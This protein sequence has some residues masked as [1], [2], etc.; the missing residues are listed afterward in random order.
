MSYKLGHKLFFLCFTFYLLSCSNTQSTLKTPPTID[1]L[2]KKVEKYNEALTNFS[3]GKEILYQ[4]Y[5]IGPEDLL[6]ID[7]Y[8]VEDVKKT[9]RVNSNGEIALPLIGIVNVK[10]MTTAE[11]EKLLAQ[12]LSKYVQETVVNVFIK[13]YRSQRVSVVGAVNNPQIYAVTGQRYLIDMLMMAGGL[14]EESGNL[15]Y[16]IRPKTMEGN[17]SGSEMIII[18]LEE[19][20][21]KGN[22]KLNIPVY[23]GDVINVPKG[24]VVFIDGAVNSPGVYPLKLGTTLIQAVAMAKGVTSDSKLSEVKIFRDNGKGER[25]II[26][27][28]LDAIRKGQ[29][30]DVKIAENDIIIIPKSGFKSLI[31]SLR[32]LFTFGSTS[33]GLG[34]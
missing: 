32:G 5:R 34:M 27:V 26:E 4:D 21:I 18:D 29:K 13:E 28:D 25:D 11:L 17:V 22:L 14:K 2:S 10:G 8:N 3:A 6:E 12:K 24:G 33:V 23:A 9:V 19:L 31:S 1:L 16:V 15:C 20:L 30:A 7:A